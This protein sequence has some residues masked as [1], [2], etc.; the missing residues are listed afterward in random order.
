MPGG[1]VDN[2]VAPGGHGCDFNIHTVNTPPR[3]M[4][5]H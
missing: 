5:P 3:I 4:M 1:E 2:M